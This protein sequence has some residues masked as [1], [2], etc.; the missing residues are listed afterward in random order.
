MQEGVIIID[1][2]LEL[3][4]KVQYFTANGNTTY[5][6]PFDY[7]RKVFVKVKET[8]NNGVSLPSYTISG[9][10]LTFDSPPPPQMFIDIY[11][12]TPTERLVSWGDG[13][14]L[15]AS[16]MTIQQ[17]Q[18]LHIL[19]E[20]TDWAKDNAIVTMD[21]GETWNAR[22]RRITNVKDPV[23]DQD[24]VTK[25]YMETVESGFIQQN[26]KIR[27]EVKQLSQDATTAANNAAKSE[28]AALGYKN[29][30]EFLL[31]EVNDKASE[32]LQNIAN[33]KTDALSA[34]AASKKDALDSITSNKNTAVSTINSTLSNSLLSMTDREQTALTNIT[35]HGST[36]LSGIEKAKNDAINMVN[37]KQE[38]AVAA[39]K[40]QEIKSLHAVKDAQTLTTT[41]LQGYV[42]NAAKSAKTAVDASKAAHDDAEAVREIA[43]NIQDTR[44]YPWKI[45]D[46]AMCIVV[47]ER[48]EQI[49]V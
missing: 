14:V 39:V 16:D 11:R 41:Y 24:A 15:K 45:E 3:K 40:D 29:D 17:V 25:K 43:G 47:T 28:Q 26:I 5:D 33:D 23:D 21:N 37:K 1:S 10:T 13:S 2:G 7:L 36:T 49:Y 44:I 6:F 18:E 35:N 27:D 19:E 20:S 4:T 48:K 22:N 12:E 34:I 42:D 30:C 32:A 46:G 38:V 9:H 31:G 8:Y